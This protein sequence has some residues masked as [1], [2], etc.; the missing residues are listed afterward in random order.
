MRVSLLGQR[1]DLNLKGIQTTGYGNNKNHDPRS[2]SQPQMNF[3][4]NLFYSHTVKCA[5]RAC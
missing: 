2:K 1:L 5:N 4:N 3:S